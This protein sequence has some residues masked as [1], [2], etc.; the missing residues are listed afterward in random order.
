MNCVVLISVNFV[1]VDN[2]KKKKKRCTRYLNIN[3]LCSEW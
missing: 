1:Y 3:E 2:L